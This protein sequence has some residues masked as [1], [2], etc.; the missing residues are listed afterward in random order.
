M[1][2]NEAKTILKESG[3]TIN[4]WWGGY[5]MPWTATYSDGS[6]EHFNINNIYEHEW[7]MAVEK[8]LSFETRDE[9]ANGR[10]LV[11]LSKDRVKERA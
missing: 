10:R 2:I 5:P 9:Y 3:Y 11:S 6:E 4:E 7:Q 1:N 8:A